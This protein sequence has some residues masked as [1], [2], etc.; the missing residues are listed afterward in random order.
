[1]KFDDFGYCPSYHERL[2]PWLVKIM[3]KYF[4]CEIQ[5]IDHVPDKEKIILVSNHA[6]ILPWDAIMIQTAILKSHPARRL[7]RPLMEDFVFSIPFLSVFMRR[8]GAV[9]AC[10]ENAEQLL[11]AG[12]LIL[13]FPEGI[14]GLSKT[15]FKKYEIQRFGRGGLIKL[16]LRT[17]SSIIPVAVKGSEESSPL[18]F[19]VEK[20]SSLHGFP[21]IPVTPTFPVLGPLGLVPLPV[22]WKIS[23]GKPLNYKNKKSDAE[24]PVIIGRLN[25]DLRMHIQKMVNEL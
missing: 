20:F 17:S 13:T 21:F 18:L 3:E 11:D 22:K 8:I 25:E 9:S 16:A 2:F 4:K 5:G 7:V 12:E 24:D 6:G 19:K 10:Q 15:Y 23:F 1:M 14:K